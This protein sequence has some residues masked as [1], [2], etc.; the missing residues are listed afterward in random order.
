MKKLFPCLLFL[1]AFLGLALPSAHAEAAKAK[2]HKKAVVK[3][4]AAKEAPKKAVAVKAK[5]SEPAAKTVAKAKKPVQN[6]VAKASSSKGKSKTS[7]KKGKGQ[8]NPQVALPK[9]NWSPNK[10]PAGRRGWCTWYA[11][12]R[13]YQYYNEKL[14]L[15][16]RPNS[17]A[18]TWYER[19]QNVVKTKEGAAGDIMVI[20]RPK[21]DRTGHV[22]FVEETVPGESWTV[23]HANFDFRGHQPLKVEII[24]GRKV[25][26]DV[27]V[28]GPRP[29]TVKLK[30]GNTVY[31]LLGFLH[32]DFGPALPP[33]TAI[34]ANT[35]QGEK[36]AKAAETPLSQDDELLLA[37]ARAIDHESEP[38]DE[39]HATDGESE[40]EAAVNGFSSLT[41]PEAAATQIVAQ[42]AC[43]CELPPRISM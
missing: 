33:D 11:D 10:F 34:A 32:K 40:D 12:G 2:D 31:N 7:K 8:K 13:F 5:K 20:K 38:L 42:E 28:P 15:N 27:F 3:A 26:T 36:E 30:G 37:V 4:E 35:A 41:D 17:N 19:A 6:K 1:A 18:F 39:E 23:T 24:D 22:M 25:F 14:E 9:S 21:G 29:G 43:G 16:P